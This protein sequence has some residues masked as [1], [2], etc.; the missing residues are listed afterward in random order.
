MGRVVSHREQGRA[1]RER[2]SSARASVRKARRF[3]QAAL[4]SLGAFR[5]V[6]AS[7]ASPTTSIQPNNSCTTIKTSRAPNPPALSPPN[8]ETELELELET[9]LPCAALSGGVGDER[10]L[11]RA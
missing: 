11:A 5:T 9:C 8:H 6:Q 1:E 4:F 3:E 10:A 2:K 7:F